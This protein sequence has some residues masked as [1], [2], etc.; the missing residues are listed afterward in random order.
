MKK[1]CFTGAQIMGLLRQ[2]EGGVYVPELCREHGIS[3]ATFPNWRAKYGGMDASMLSQMKALEAAQ[4]AVT[5][6]SASF[7]TCCGSELSVLR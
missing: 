4:S 3:S 5:C 7:P 1:S 2:V 6:N